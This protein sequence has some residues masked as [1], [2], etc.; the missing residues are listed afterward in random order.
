MLHALTAIERSTEVDCHCILYQDRSEK[1]LV[2]RLTRNW[3]R[4]SIKLHAYLY[5]K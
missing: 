1:H 2:D 4:L 3:L 5:H